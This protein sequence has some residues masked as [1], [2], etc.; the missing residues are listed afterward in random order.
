MN[1]NDRILATWL[2]IDNENVVALSRLAQERGSNEEVKQFAKRMIEDHQQMITKLHPGTGA[3]ATGTGAP[4]T[5]GRSGDNPAGGTGHPTAGGK[6]QGHEPREASGQRDPARGEGGSLD[7]VQ[8]KRE[9]GQRCQSSAR[10]ELE[11]KQGAEFDKCFMLMQVGAHVHAVDTM[12][13]FK[14]HA[15]G[16]LRQTITDALPT[17]QQHLDHAKRIAKSLEGAA[18][19]DSKG[20]T[21]R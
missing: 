7:I 10:R 15:T 9:L 8:L 20:G 6:G 13:V 19:D 4:G 18:G 17:V 11:S 1:R 2:V 3:G 16:Q 21:G 14:N 5:T 12:E